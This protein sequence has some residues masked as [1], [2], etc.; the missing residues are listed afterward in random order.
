MM[1]E[2]SEKEREFSARTDAL[3][4]TTP[5]SRCDCSKCPCKALCDWL[6]E[7]DPNR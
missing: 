6:T 4:E 7:N 2:Y 1:S 5:P 3:C